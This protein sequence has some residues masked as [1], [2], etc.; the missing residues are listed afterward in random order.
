[1]KRRNFINQSLKMGALASLAGA[2]PLELLANT[3]Y[4]KPFF[5]I[6]LAQ[7]SFHRALFDG[8]MDHLEFAAKA[9]SLG[10]E[11]LEYV[12]RFFSTK[13]KD[14]SYLRQMNA[15]AEDEGV[16]NLLIMVGRE[17]NL[18]SPDKAERSKAITNHYKWVEAAQ[19]LGC[20]SIRV[21]LRG[22]IKKTEAAMASLD[23]LNRLAEFAQKANINIL[24]ENHGGFSSDGS[25][26]ASIMKKVD[27]NNCGTL[28]DFGNFCIEKGEDKLCLEEYNK[29]QGI[30]ELLPFAKGVSAKSYQFNDKGDETAIDYYRMLRTVKASG[31]TGYIGIEYEGSTHSEKEGVILTR[32][33]L[34]KAGSI[35]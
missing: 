15:R 23:S 6:S 33:L 35:V 10:C 11:G 32:D 7:W 29:Y 5:K 3:P 8:S 31:Y 1:M 34:L 16:K 24:V 19:F 18:A 21:D 26:L 12:N 14:N 9:R 30:K 27:R 17:G 2:I 28:P 4:T 22:G 13:A 25:W 20:H